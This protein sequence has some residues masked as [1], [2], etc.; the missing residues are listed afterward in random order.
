MDYYVWTIFL[1]KIHIKKPCC[2]FVY[3]EKSVKEVSQNLHQACTR[4]SQKQQRPLQLGVLW[5]GRGTRE[6]LQTGGSVIQGVRLPSPS[7][8]VESVEV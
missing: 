6:G 2:T 8:G 4:H 3:S 1:T 5:V 7:F